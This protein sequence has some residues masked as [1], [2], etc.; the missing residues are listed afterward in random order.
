[1]AT[2]RL[3]A[4][5]FDNHGRIVVKAG[6]MYRLPGGGADTTQQPVSSIFQGVDIVQWG[7]T[8]Y[9]LAMIGGVGQLVE[10]VA[11]AGKVAS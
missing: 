11:N 2:A 5:F 4:G 8:G 10:V 3:D 6:S 1:M 9:C 7:G